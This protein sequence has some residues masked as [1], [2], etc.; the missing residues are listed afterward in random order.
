[1]KADWTTGGYYGSVG[2]FYACRSV[3]H[4]IHWEII[5]DL[6]IFSHKEEK[7]FKPKN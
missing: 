1:M 2:F 7:M 3:N 4:S 6:V 5:R